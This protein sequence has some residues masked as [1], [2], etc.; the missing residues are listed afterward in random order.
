MIDPE[1]SPQKLSEQI[2][3]TNKIDVEVR[4]QTVP[5]TGVTRCIGRIFTGLRTDNRAIALALRELADSLDGAAND[6][7]RERTHEP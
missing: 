1:Y 6:D 5:T 3:A 7:D 2:K 4:V